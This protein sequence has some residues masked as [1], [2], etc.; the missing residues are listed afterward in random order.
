MRTALYGR[1]STKDKGQDTENQL[2]ALREFAAAN[3]WDVVKEYVDTVSGSG[4]AHRPAFEQM[5]T[6]AANRQVDLVLF[7]SLDRLSR[8][9][10]AKTVG[11]L[12]R[13]TTAGVS[14]RSYT[15][16][17]LDSCGIF[18]D[19]VLAILAVVAKQERIRI[20]ERT[21]AG[22]A[23]ARAKG[24]IGGR[25]PIEKDTARILELRAGGLSLS[26]IAAQVSVSRATVARV[27]TGAGK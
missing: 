21:M 19:A 4:K 26:E 5:M 9:G 18:K 22:L 15:E 11:Y 3:H 14:W 6:D 17:Y 1:V 8:E 20:S 2:R 16:Q 13:L 10:V 27:C 25:K 12:D 7:W 23:T 24:R